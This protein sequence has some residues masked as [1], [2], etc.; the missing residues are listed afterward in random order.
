MDKTDFT[1]TIKGIPSK[2]LKELWQ[3][4]MDWMMKN[5]GEIAEYSNSV[6]VDFD[7]AMGVHP[8]GFYQIMAAGFTLQAMKTGKKIV[9][10]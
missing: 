8:E 5:M 2:E 6:S 3:Q 9:R 1:I 10:E 4:N 7:Y